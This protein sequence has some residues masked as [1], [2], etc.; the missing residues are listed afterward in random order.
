[1]AIHE[2]C[3]V[4]GISDPRGDCAR[5]AY[6]GLYSLQHRGQEACGIATINDRE[7]SYHKDV[8]LVGEVFTPELLHQLDGTMAVGHVRYATTGG[9]RRENAQP[10]TLKYVKGTLALAHNGNL[11]GTQELRTGFEY[12]GAIFQ[13]T[14]D[15]ELIAYAIAQERLRCGSAE[16]AVVRAMKLLR[17]AYSL[18]V[19]S[20]QKL[21]AARDPWGFRPLCMGRRGDAVIFASES[22][23]LHAVGAQYERELEPGEVVVAEGTQVRSIKEN[24]AGASSHMCIFEYIYFARPDSDICGQSVHEARRLAG[25]YLARESAVDADVVIGVPDSGLDAAMG[26]AEESGLP[27]VI[28]LVKNRYIGRTFI[29]PG[30]ESREQAVRIKLGPLRS[31]IEGKRVVVIDDSIVRG[32][33][34]RQIVSLLREAGATEVH[35][36]SSA[37]PFIAP[38]YF[39]TDIPDREQLIAC[40]YTVDEIRDMIGADSLAFLS[41]DA[42]HRIA[43]DAKCGFCDGCFTGKYPIA[44]D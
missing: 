33:T 1:M 41:L 28:G 2:E 13:T 42:L 12:R 29:T 25:K 31:S 6:Y 36:R 37:P 24:C 14:T 32:T 4:F 7:L 27:Y 35:M 44:L 40:Q 39:G 21:I 3:G 23:A 30:Q 17:G 10:L 9:T 18:I 20:P 15:S 43:P 22:C 38:C 5:T 16:E 8:G 26:Y 19:M 11:V 34:S